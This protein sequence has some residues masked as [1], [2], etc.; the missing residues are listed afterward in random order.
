LF[1]IALII[2]GCLIYKDY[3]IPWDESIQTQV[4][5]LNFRYIFRGDHTLLSFP[6]RFYGA[7]F[8]LPLLWVTSR[9]SMP[10]HLVIFLI[11]V[12]GLILFC[13][14]SRRLFHNLWW[15]FLAS[16][17]LAASP[18]IFADAFY[19]SKDIPFLVASITAI[20]TLVILSDNLA[21]KHNWWI[22]SA[23]MVMHAGASAV[24]ISTR[25]PGVVIIPLT[26]FFLLTKT[27]ESPVSWKL[28]LAILFGYLAL[29]IGLTILFWPILWQNPWREFVNA[30][31]EMSK[32]PFDR[33]VLYEGKYFPAENLP[34]QYL[35]V[36]IGITTPVIVL[37]GMFACIIG[38]IG[39]ISTVIKS[40][41]KSQVLKSFV[42]EISVW[43]VVIG[44]LA[45]PIA[46]VYIFHSVLYDGW[47]QMF[48]VY[49]AIV[50]ISLRGL[51]FLYHWM[52]RIP[53]RSN[54]IRIIAGILLLSGLVE[55]VWFMVCYHPYE[56]VYFNIFAGD[57]ITL[58]ERFELD[59]WGLAYKQGIDYILANDTSNAI[60]IFVADPPGQDYINSGLTSENKSRLIPVKDPNDANYFVSEFRWHPEDYPYVD[61]FYSVNIR[62]TKIM[63]VYRLR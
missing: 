11:F 36:W 26:L 35:P 12:F 2:L 48:F 23:I 3:G 1:F 44:W 4:G 41:K 27:I 57:P 50:L 54:V 19:N 17:I 53:V 51:I 6:D 30:F 25:V 40:K 61:E 10:R 18:R 9:L 42:S 29:T 38:W 21:Q 55:P 13:F 58:R 14:L 45:I 7:I 15:G 39:S 32:Y 24:L 56:N 63:V 62:G 8:E 60:K 46:A 5:A 16:G 59:Y 31:T 20:W 43:L 22:V 28:V 47:R 49:P 52:L 34:W 33:M 37:A